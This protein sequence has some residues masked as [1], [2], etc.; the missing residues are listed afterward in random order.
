M[1][2]N[3]EKTQVS[4][5]VWVNYRSSCLIEERIAIKYKIREICLVAKSELHVENRRGKQSALTI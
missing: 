4:T 1:E 5:Q 2:I 3:W